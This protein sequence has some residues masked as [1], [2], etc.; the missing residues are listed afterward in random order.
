MK[1]KL[2]DI[3]REVAE[4]MGKLDRIKGVNSYLCEVRSGKTILRENWEGPLRKVLGV[5][6]GEG[7]LKIFPA[8][9]FK[10]KYI[11]V[12]EDDYFAKLGKFNVELIV[13]EPSGIVTGENL[14]E[15]FKAIKIL[16]DLGIKME[17][18]LK[19]VR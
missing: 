1:K 10:N 18:N 17:I 6:N 13:K 16:E 11:E 19:V 12:Y 8:I 2:K 3:A 9:K 4:I 14:P 5:E 15:M 7:L